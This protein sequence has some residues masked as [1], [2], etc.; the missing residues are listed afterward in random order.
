MKLSVIIVNYNVKYFLEQALQSVRKAAETVATEVFVVDNNSVDDSVEML[1]EQFPEVKLIANKKNVGFS[2]ANNQAIE[3]AQ[4]EYVLLL[5][6][7]TVV[8]EDTF[9]KTVEFMDA[10]PQAGAL[11]VQ[12]IDGKGKFLPESKRGFPSPE[13]A[14]YKAFGI[15]RFFPQS[16]RFNRY[17]M[18]HLPKEE[19]HEVEVLSGAFMLLRRS[20]LQEIGLLDETFF[21]YGEDIDL[22]YRVIK[23]G[24]KNYYFADTCIIHYKGESTKKGSLNYVRTFYKAM[25]IFARKHFQGRSAN[26]LVLMLYVAIYLRAG[27]TL[28]SN[29]IRRWYLPVL[30][31]ALIFGGLFVIKD[32][33]A[34]LRFENPDYFP[35]SLLYFNFPLYIGT[36]LISVYFYGGY[37]RMRNTQLLLK[38]LVTGT[39]LIAAIYG[40]LPSH[41]RSSRMLILMG[42]AWASM[43]M[44]SLRMILYFSQNG[45]FLFADRQQWNLLIVGDLSESERVQQL[46][47]RAEVQMNFLG[48]VSAEE[49]YSHRDFLG[50]VYQLEEIAHIYKVNEVIFCAA[51][52]SSE[53]IIYWMAR[54]GPDIQYKIVPEQ[55]INIIGSNSKNRAGDLYSIEIQFSIAVTRHRRNKRVLDILLSLLLLLAFPLLVFFSKN[56][57]GYFR[58]SLRVLLGQR[59]W[60]GYQ[61]HRATPHNLPR[62]KPGILSPVDALKI[63]PEDPYTLHRLNLFYAKDYDSSEDL[64]IFWRGRR[65]WGRAAMPSLPQEKTAVEEAHLTE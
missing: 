25:I 33:W 49:A 13:V 64:R 8:R 16:R 31:V 65:H 7:D 41:L 45:G 27:L 19:T 56:K 1:R 23:G 12:M 53:T 24:Y 20:V 26:L 57:L 32:L 52:L 11:G 18:G 10:H 54:L 39:V 5:N 63:R 36:W 47:H 60:V 15:N 43:S 35:S 44:L 46:L 17:Y 38:G 14:F 58:N 48:T 3:Q 22:S 28:L 9:Q 55:S 51:N 37:D 4:G 34:V 42:A 6:P 40:F 30:D 61:R 29:G 62:L 21:M 2:V 50:S 59:S